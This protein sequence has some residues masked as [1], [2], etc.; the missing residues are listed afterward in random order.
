[1]NPSVKQSSDNTPFSSHQTMH[2]RTKILKEY[3]VG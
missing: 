3:T 2:M 1:M